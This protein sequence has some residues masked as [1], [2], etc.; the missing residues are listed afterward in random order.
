MKRLKLSV[1]LIIIGLSIAVVG[2]AALSSISFDRSV[3]AGRVIVDTDENAAIQ[4]TNTMDWI[5]WEKA[6]QESQLNSCFS[7]ISSYPKKPFGM[8]IRWFNCW[9]AF[10]EP[11]PG[12]PIYS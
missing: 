11:P 3:S 1:L 12:R 10:Y 8:R 5:N 9:K 6:L 7:G 2:S 4:I